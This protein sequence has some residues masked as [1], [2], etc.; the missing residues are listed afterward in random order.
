M[1]KCSKFCSESSSLSLRGYALAY[2]ENMAFTVQ[3]FSSEILIL[4]I[5]II[6]DTFYLAL[7]SN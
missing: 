5:I 4:I 2:G 1:L 6:V 3:G 7:F